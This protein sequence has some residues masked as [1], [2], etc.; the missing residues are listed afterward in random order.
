MLHIFCQL[1]LPLEQK[2]RDQNFV[3]KIIADLE[4]KKGDQKEKKNAWN[5][6]KFFGFLQV[7]RFFV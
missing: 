4:Q 1:P 6:S 3:Q 2:A 7:L 5:L